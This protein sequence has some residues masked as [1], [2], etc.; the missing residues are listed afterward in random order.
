MQSFLDA[1]S[2]LQSLVPA[3]VFE[4][5][6]IW[7]LNI[8]IFY[9]VFTSL[10]TLFL[11]AKI[12]FYNRFLAYRGRAIKVERATG[13][14]R[15]L[16]LGD[17]TAVGTG[18]SRS[19]DTIA[20]RLARD[21]P[22]A[23]IINRGVNGAVTADIGKQLQGAG[24]GK[25]NVVI[26]SVGGNDAVHFTG[27]HEM[28]SALQ[29][30]LKQA[31]EISNH[32][33]LLLIYNNIASAPIFPAFIRWRLRRSADTMQLVFRKVAE[34]EQVPCIDLFSQGNDN[35]FL[36]EPRKFF[37]PDGIHPSSEG[38]RL[39]YNRMWRTLT[40]RGYAF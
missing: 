9:F 12:S 19:E 14:K 38:Y 34:E 8:F 29:A 23:A 28:Q 31:K 6:L 13:E 15:I 32:R 26:I 3:D 25:F 7:G 24:E 33:V 20:G 40:E 1:F 16:I 37:A 30:S 4:R 39:W 22:N 18:A 17:S 10:R 35:P 27:R 36:R 5:L 11:L 21:F 2:S